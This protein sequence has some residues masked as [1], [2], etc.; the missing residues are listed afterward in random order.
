MKG[1]TRILAYIILRGNTSYIRGNTG[2][3][4]VTGKRTQYTNMMYA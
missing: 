2:I 1:N 3:E 4:G